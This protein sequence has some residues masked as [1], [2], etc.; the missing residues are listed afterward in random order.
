MRASRL[1]SL[2]LLL[3]TRDRMTA[4]QLADAL[5]VSVRTIYRDV[6]AL[7]ASGVPIYGEPGN[8]G[9]YRLL[10]GYRTRLT[11]LTAG[12]AQMLFLTGLPAAAAQL[13]LA[14]A[15]T[16]ARLK[17]TAALPAE[18][19]DRA[20]RVADRFHLDAPSWYH[21]GDPTPHLAV[22]ADAVWNQHTLQIRYLRWAK[23]QE[24]TRIV[25][26]YGLVLKAG[27][28]Y[29]VAR[30]PGQFRTY[31]ISRILDAHALPDSFDR[32]ED[33]TLAGY[34]HDYLEHFDQRRH[35]HQATL[36]VSPR[37]L[38][39]MPHLWEPA[40]VHAAR[41]T[42]TGP[43]PQGWTQITIPIESVEVALPEL[44]KLGADAEVLTPE[45]LRAH[46]IHTL[47]AMN[48]VYD[49]PNAPGTPHQP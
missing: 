8:E 42:A 30:H 1:V 32:V 29:L 38:D 21:E 25:Q 43:D 2:L 47:R 37:G 14:T 36:R 24:I 15:V 34:W 46:I 9:G 31:R 40:V 6:E 33:F 5:E 19:R 27:H 41:Q 23:P 16:G 3:Q 22:V 17:L 26:P 20:N 49:Y 45:N 12:E 10:E 48:H 7:N 39:L 28:W 18:L 13:G 35:Q 11:G 4:Q 44:L